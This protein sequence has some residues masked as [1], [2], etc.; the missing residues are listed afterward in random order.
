MDRAAR[1]RATVAALAALV[2]AG[3]AA[4]L[5]YSLQPRGDT[6]RVVVND[7]SLTWDALFSEFEVVGFTAQ[8]ERYQG[9]RISDALNQTGVSSP[10][11]HRYRVT[12]ADGYQK[13]FSWSDVLNGYL[14]REGKKTVFP[15]LTKSFWVRDVV[16]IEVL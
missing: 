7:R 3:S 10:E 1:V 2:L 15:G 9:V 14:V 16:T 8:G 4:A 12:G 13:D 11:A 6:S 5:H